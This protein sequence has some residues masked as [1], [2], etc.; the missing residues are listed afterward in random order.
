[1]TP[2]VSSTKFYLDIMFLY[3]ISLYITNKIKIKK[4]T[5][6]QTTGIVSEDN[7]QIVEIETSL[8]PLTHINVIAH[9]HGLSHTLQ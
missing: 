6:Y 5:K 8:I 9:F 4:N 3:F 7:R 1:M 2:L